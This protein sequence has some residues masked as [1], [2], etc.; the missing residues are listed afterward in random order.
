M[1]QEQENRCLEIRTYLNNVVENC[2]E[3]A[4]SI[5]TIEERKEI[6]AEVNCLMP[7]VLFATFGIMIST[8]E[9]SEAL[10]IFDE[11]NEFVSDAARAMTKS[12]LESW[13]L[14]QERE[15]ANGVPQGE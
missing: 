14:K 12:V 4:Q 8:T 10:N 13:R 3:L 15:S 2:Q 1:T 9:P 11:M 5:T 6:V 7:R